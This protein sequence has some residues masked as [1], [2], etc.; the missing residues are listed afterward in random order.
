MNAGTQDHNFPLEESSLERWQ[1]EEKSC[2]DSD[3]RGYRQNGGPDYTVTSPQPTHTQ[4]IQL[5]GR[6]CLF[7][8]PL[9]SSQ[10][11]PP[12]QATPS[13]YKHTHTQYVHLC[14]CMCLAGTSGKEPTCQ[15]RRRKRRGFNPWVRKMPWRRAFLPGESHGQRILAGYGPWGRKESDTTE[16][17]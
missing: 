14:R 16:A 5:W 2:K 1:G 15:C 17:T 11:S 3:G 4:C 6:S 13:T 7:P 10:A 12:C 8:L 9:S